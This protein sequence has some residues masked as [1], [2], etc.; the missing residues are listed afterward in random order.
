MS[1][2]TPIVSAD[3]PARPYP[4]FPLFPH[5]TGRWAKKI[6]GKLHYFGK[7]K[8]ELYEESWQAALELYK[9]QAEDLHAGR[10]PRLR[11]AQRV[12]REHPRAATLDD[13]APQDV[14]GQAVEHQVDPAPVH[15]DREQRPPVRPRPE[16]GAVHASRF[17]QG[18]ALGRQPL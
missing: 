2:S 14:E 3:K 18:A 4:N 6:K 16:Q 8:G 12:E 5:A 11:R 10:K 9:Q 1:K 15:E 13:R 7:W 17:E